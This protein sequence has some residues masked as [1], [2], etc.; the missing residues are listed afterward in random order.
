ME[1]YKFRAWSKCYNAFLELTAFEIH[2]GY[3][4][5]IFHDGDYIGYDKEDISLMQYTGLNDKN[6]VEIYAGDICKYV[7]FKGEETIIQVW[8]S[9]ED[10][11]FNFGNRN[12]SMIKE[13]I[14]VIGNIYEN[15]SLLLDEDSICYGCQHYTGGENDCDTSNICIE[16]SLNKYKTN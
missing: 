12:L 1:T 14:E 9:K 2:R 3:I 7:N 16:G 10:A 4:D 11:S 13:K 5:G 8:W 6:G 15:Q